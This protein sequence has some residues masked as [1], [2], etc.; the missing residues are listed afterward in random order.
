MSNA[1][2]TVAANDHL[3]A[4]LRDEAV[5]LTGKTNDFKP[6]FDLVG[7][8]RF[9]LIGEST[10]GTEEFYRL[11]ADLTR[12]LIRDF[13][14]NGVAVEGDWPDCLR[15]NRYV[16]GDA[17]IVTPKAALSGFTRFPAWMWRNRAVAEFIDWLRTYNTARSPKSHAGFYGLDLYSL[18]ASI[19]AVIG[20]LDRVD[21]IAAQRAR[22]HYACFDHGHRLAL[23]PQ[24]Y[25]YAATFGI[26]DACERQA[27]QQLV[28]LRRRATAY[29]E[30]DAP[31]TE[32]DVFFAERNAKIVLSA[33]SYYRAMFDDRS[34]SWNLR[35]QHMA[36]TLYALADHLTLPHGRRARLVVWAHNSHVGDARATEMSQRGEM[37]LGQL[38]RSAHGRDC[39]SI[40]FS[41]YRGSV[42][43]ASQWDG[44]VQFKHLRAALRGSYEDLFH[45]TGRK[46]FLLC[47]RDNARLARL[48]S[49]SRLQR[50]VGVLYLPQTERE[51]HY[52]YA[53]LPEQFDALIH[54]DD[55][56]ALQA[57][58]NVATQAGDVCETYPTGV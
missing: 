30:G 32:D 29:L 38:V 17:K 48:L 16:R 12:V 3:I 13:G 6:L 7:D 2:T 24:S 14:F 22:V 44:P 49:L 57:F 35:D 25:G 31:V 9:V 23:N 45:C 1:M 40:G 52:I 34:S 41:T 43:A 54:I 50:A 56:T 20:F 47:L 21:P 28:D 58:P 19:E 33:E 26:T 8:A 18:Y 15:V 11:R 36:E 39:A 27:I 46:D 51:S 53:S 42:L 4:L 37:N 5:Q 10:H 55:T